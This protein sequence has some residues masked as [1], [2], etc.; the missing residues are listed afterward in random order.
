ML[1]RSKI[2]NQNVKI[3]TSVD[4]VPDRKNLIRWLNRNDINIFAY[5]DMPWRNAV[6]S[7]LDLALSAK[8]PVA[9]IYGSMFK[10]VFDVPEIFLFDTEHWDPIL[11]KRGPRFETEEE[12]KLA[13][14]QNYSR[15][16]MGIYEQGLEPLQ[17]LYVKWSEQNFIDA[18]EREFDT[19]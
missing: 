13:L 6:S 10:H 2:A 19:L 9:L 1:F 11:G 12:L 7:S 5:Q 15:T 3:W 8:K 16:I 4:Y 18:F 17:Q 14:D